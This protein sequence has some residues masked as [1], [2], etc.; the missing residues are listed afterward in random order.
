MIIDLHHVYVIHDITMISTY[1]I[2]YCHDLRNV[3]T[4]KDMNPTYLYQ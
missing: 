4:C 2:I 1:E 3:N